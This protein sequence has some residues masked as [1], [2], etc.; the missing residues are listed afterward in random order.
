MSKFKKGDT[1]PGIISIVIGVLAIIYNLS[2]PNMAIFESSSNGFL[3]AGFMPFLMS[4]LLIVFGLV[5]TI[6]GLKENGQ[7]DYFK[8]DEEKKKNLRRVGLFVVLCIAFLTAW[9]LT[10]QFFVCLPIYAFL[11]NVLLKRKWLFTIL[12]TIIVSAF[13]YCLFHLGF[14]IRFMP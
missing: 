8:L 14:S 10:K 12:F 1:I 11:V 4:L 7:L 3:G 5:L 6:K 13:V 2:K 9:K